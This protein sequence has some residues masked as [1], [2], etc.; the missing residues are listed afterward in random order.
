MQHLENQVPSGRSFIVCKMSGLSFEIREAYSVMGSYL[1][2]TQVHPLFA[3]PES[4]K[5]LEKRIIQR[6]WNGIPRSFIAGYIIYQLVKQKKL[7]FS[8]PESLLRVNNSLATNNKETLRSC[9]LLLR[10]L[11]TT[12]NNFLSKTPA[13]NLDSV[14]ERDITKTFLGR[15]L[16]ILDEEEQE[17]IQAKWHEEMLLEQRR[18]AKEAEVILTIRNRSR[19]T[20]EK[21]LTRIPASLRVLSRFVGEQKQPIWKTFISRIEKYSLEDLA[22]EYETI[23]T[24]INTVLNRISPANKQRYVSY[25][26]EKTIEKYLSLL[27]IE[28]AA[29][30]EDLDAWL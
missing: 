24:T 20:E 7:L 17:R 9:V 6:V 5:D 23:K 18:K 27:E 22:S 21:V 26:H 2:Y 16:R 3:D 30:Q 12:L 15:Y 14:P 10:N 8:H 11:E 25:L 29:I 13:I 4:I 19:L 1:Y 28:H